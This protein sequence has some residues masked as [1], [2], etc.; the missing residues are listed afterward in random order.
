VSLELQD[1]TDDPLTVGAQN[2]GVYF[3][4][5]QH[6]INVRRQNGGLSIID[7]WLD[8]TPSNKMLLEHYNELKRA[9]E[10]PAL[11]FVLGYSSV[12][13]ALGRSWSAL[14]FIIPTK[15]WLAGFLL[16]N[17]MRT[18]LGSTNQFIYIADTNGR[19][20]K[21]QIDGSGWTTYGESGRGV[22]EFA[23][24]QGLHYDASTGFI[25]VGDQT[26]ASGEDRIVKTKI[27]GTGW[28][29]Y[30]ENGSG[31]GQFRTPSAVSFDSDTGFIYIAD[32]VND[33]IVKTKIDG[34]G[35]TSYGTSGAGVGNFENP[36]GID[37]DA[38]TGF[39]YV[40]DTRNDRIVKTKIDGS[41]W[42]TLGGFDR[43][44]GVHY[45]PASGF[46]Y[47]ADTHNNRIVKTKIDGSG[48]TTYGTIGTGTG[49]FGFLVDIAYDP[50][51]EFIYIT[52]SPNARIVKTKIDGSGWKA[53]GTSGSGVGQF[54]A[55]KGISFG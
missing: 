38:S 8:T 30:G 45:D 43:L 25:Y 44:E 24:P 7:G 6:N 21:T 55:P 2:Y 23:F 34:T 22:G 31:V 11:L 18:I 3:S 49:Q 29:T 52:D 5:I 9:I 33:R 42:T 20:V 13:D 39:I 47:V 48:W 12:E 4:E 50:A 10:D 53:Y 1:W 36:A 32:E 28:A 16:L 46:I 41:G 26:D 15:Q 35:W 51:S 40:G 27:D 17:D 14:P 19:I 54:F 37:Y